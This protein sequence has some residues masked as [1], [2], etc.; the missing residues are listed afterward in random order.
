MPDQDTAIEM[1]VD[2]TGSIELNT[3]QATYVEPEETAAA[4]TLNRV[5]DTVAG[6]LVAW[7]TE[8]VDSLGA[9]YPGPGTFGV[10][11][12]DFVVERPA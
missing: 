8:G 12:S 3:F 4:L 2:D 7:E 6:G 10:H 5:W 9:Q 1:G 11:T